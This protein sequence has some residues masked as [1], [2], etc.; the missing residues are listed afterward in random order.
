[1]ARANAATSHQIRSKSSPISSSPRL[2][3][4]SAQGRACVLLIELRPKEG[5][6][7]IPPMW[8]SR[9]RGGEVGE[10][11]QPTGLAEQTARLPSV[12]GRETQSS[13]Q[14]ELDHGKPFLRRERRSKVTRRGMLSRRRDG[15]ITVA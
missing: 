6:Q 15:P 3:S 13:E 10:E 2:T 14:P 4:V 7:R 12:C 1:M 5:E 11:G 8:A 9:R